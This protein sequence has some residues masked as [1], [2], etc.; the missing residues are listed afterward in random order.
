[1]LCSF[2]FV[3]RVSV[4]V[5]VHA[6]FVVFRVCVLVVFGPSIVSLFCVRFVFCA[7]SISHAMPV[8][9]YEWNEC[10]SYLSSRIFFKGRVLTPPGR[11][12]GAHF[13]LLV[14]VCMRGFN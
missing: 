14:C 11:E 4:L 9:F 7:S 8:Y 13:I 2:V 10:F 3:L 6:A 1:M 12:G 5:V